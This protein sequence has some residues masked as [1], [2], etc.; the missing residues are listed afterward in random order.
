MGFHVGNTI[1]WV[2]KYV[3]FRSFKTPVFC[4]ATPIVILCVA[5]DGDISIYLFYFIYCQCKKIYSLCKEWKIQIDKHKLCNFNMFLMLLKMNSIGKEERVYAKSV[6][7][8]V[9]SLKATFQMIH[10]KLITE[11]SQTTRDTSF[12]IRFLE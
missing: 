4:M 11:C 7:M 3:L 1:N 9:I 5:V 6:H 12:H 8:Q 10:D 2:S